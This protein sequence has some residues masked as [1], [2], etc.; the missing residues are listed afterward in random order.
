MADINKTYITLIPMEI[1][2]LHWTVFCYVQAF[3]KKIDEFLE[4]SGQVKY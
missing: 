1:E 4:D 3:Y 2:L